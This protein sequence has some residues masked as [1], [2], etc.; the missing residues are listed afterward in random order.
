MVI[1]VFL[2]RRL[3]PVNSTFRF[4]PPANEVW[5]KVIFLHLCVILFTGRGV[6]FPACITG[7]MTKGVCIWGAWADPPPRDTWDTMEYGLQVG[8][9]HPT[10][11]HSR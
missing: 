3:A 8:G 2:S 6:G 10:G 4:L 11:M 1:I 5:G 9:M 7:H